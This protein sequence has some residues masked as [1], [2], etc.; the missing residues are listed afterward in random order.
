MRCGRWR[1][2][3]LTEDRGFLRSWV[4][5]R[6]TSPPCLWFPNLADLARLRPFTCSCFDFAQPSQRQ[7]WISPSRWTLVVDLGALWL[8]NSRRQAL[9][10]LAFCMVPLCR[11]TFEVR[12]GR[13]RDARARLA[14]MYSVPP[15]GPWWP[16]VGPRLDRGVRPRR[17]ATCG[18]ICRQKLRPIG[19]LSPLT[20]TADAR[21][22]PRS[23]SS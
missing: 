3:E 7:S 15:T 16:A 4:V 11:L 9:T 13:R 1:P 8:F 21:C 6:S 18:C 12:R 2:N 20:P 17:A 5:R 10:L 19:H 23:A 14:K 22:H